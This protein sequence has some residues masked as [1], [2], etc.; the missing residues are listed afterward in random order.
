MERIEDYNTNLNKLYEAY[1][2]KD[3][4]K[5]LEYFDYVFKYLIGHDREKDAFYLLFLHGYSFGVPNKYINYYMKK[6]NDI[7]Y[8]YDTQCDGLRS[9]VYGICFRDAKKTLKKG[10]HSFEN[11]TESLIEE[12]L[13]ERGNDRYYKV[14]NKVNQ[15]AIADGYDSIFNYLKTLNSF[16]FL[17][18]S[19]KDLLYLVKVYI[20]AN[21]SGNVPTPTNDDCLMIFPLLVQNN[22]FIS[23]KQM[24]DDYFDKNPSKDR[25]V[26]ATY[27]VLSKIVPLIPVVEETIEEP[28]TEEIDGEVKSL[29]D[30]LILLV[31]DEHMSFDDALKQLPLSDEEKNNAILMMAKDC[32]YKG[33]ISDG[34]RYLNMVERSSHKGS[35]IKK[36]VSMLRSRKKFLQF[37]ENKTLVFTK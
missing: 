9:D 16:G 37:D 23:A 31:R 3:K 26:N 8:D 21:L 5:E 30:T 24:L 15:K 17:S 4:K 36:Q 12:Y 29:I 19:Q 11:E 32:Y 7:V 13:I 22:D 27:L 2:N 6:Y 20:E 10:E 33:N 14:E 1:K 28:I 18:S 34:D 35:E 25:N